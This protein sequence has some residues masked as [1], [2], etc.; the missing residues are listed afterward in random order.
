MGCFDGGVPPSAATS[1]DLRGSRFRTALRDA[2]LSRDEAAR[3]LRHAQQTRRVAPVAA[4][5]DK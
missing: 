4:G 2:V 5:R 1:D 3:K